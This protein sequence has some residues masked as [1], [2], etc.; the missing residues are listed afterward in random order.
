MLFG[1]VVQENDQVEL[2]GTMTKN[3]PVGV[4]GGGVRIPISKH[5]GLRADTRVYLISNRDE[6]F[7]ST[8][9]L[10]ERYGGVS[11][12][13]SLYGYF[14]TRTTPAIQLQSARPTQPE[15]NVSFS[16]PQI[17]N[18]RTFEGTGIETSIAV[19]VGVYWRF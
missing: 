16:G 15:P 17:S 18:F 7:V 10:A 5:I 13:Y 6:T 4:A 1:G 3:K 2:T 19:T 11:N 12:E 14:D 8:G 9:P